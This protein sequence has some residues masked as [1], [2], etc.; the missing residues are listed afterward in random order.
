[1]ATAKTEKT[2]EELTENR[3]WWWVAEK[4]R[5]KRLD[6]LRKAA[7]KKGASGGEYTPGLKICMTQARLFTEAWRE[8]ELDP[9]MLRKAKAHANVF[10][11]IPLFIT[12]HAQIMGYLGAAPHEMIWNIQS[13]SPW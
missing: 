13:C 8:N 5:S 6:Y 2:V 9:I 10:R 3:E 11:N 4:T 12:D 7:W 1:M